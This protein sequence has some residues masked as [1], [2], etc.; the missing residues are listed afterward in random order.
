[1]ANS[2]KP[3]RSGQDRIYSQPREAIQD[4]VFDTKVVSVFE[5]MINRSVPGY[6][7]LLSMIPV[8]TRRFV[9]A[10]SNCYDLGCSLGAATLSMQQSVMCDDVTIFAIDN[11]VAMVSK[12]RDILDKHRNQVNVDVREADINTVTIDNASMVVMNFTLQF[13]DEASR[14]NV[15]DRIYQ[16]MNTGGL[17]LLSEKIRFDSDEQQQLMT[18]LHHEFKK[19]NGYSDLEISQK[20]TALENVLVPETVEGHIQR[21]RRAG[22]SQVYCWYQCFNFISIMA[23]K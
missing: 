8:F 7:G 23:V 6:A 16:G 1:M 18:E 4:F 13:I 21:L 17:F 5:D 3:T 14:D 19:A 2:K 22:F 20:R 11:S 12:C 10:S 9:T 15:V